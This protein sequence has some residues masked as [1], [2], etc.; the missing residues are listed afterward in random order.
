MEP[1]TAFIDRV[2][3]LKTFKLYHVKDTQ[4]TIEQKKQRTIIEIH[5]EMVCYANLT[6]RIEKND[7]IPKDK[8]EKVSLEQEEVIKNFVGDDCFYSSFVL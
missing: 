5:F 7:K 4:D 6:Q 2:Y 1:L 3:A 8:Y